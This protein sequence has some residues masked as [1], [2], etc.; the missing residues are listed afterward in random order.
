MLFRSHTR[1]EVFARIANSPRATSPFSNLPNSTGRSHWG[2][3]VTAEDM[4]ALT[5]VTPRTVVQV[6]FVEWTRGG[7]LRHAK[8]V[9]LRDDKPARAVS[10]HR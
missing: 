9:G 5:W 7:S 8:F 2:E 4:K 10:R 1:A 6:S 3:G